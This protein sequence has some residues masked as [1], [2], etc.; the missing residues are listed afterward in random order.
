MSTPDPHTELQRAREQLARARAAGAKPSRLETL[1]ANV[2]TWREKT[3]QQN[4]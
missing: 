4:T 1:R 3:R 2:R